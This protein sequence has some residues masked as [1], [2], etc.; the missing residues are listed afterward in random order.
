MTLLHPILAAVASRGRSWLVTGVLVGSI[1]VAGYSLGTRFA[2]GREPICGNVELAKIAVDDAATSSTAAVVSEDHGI[3]LVEG[4]FEVPLARVDEAKASAR[5][6]RIVPALAHGRPIGTKLYAIRSGSIAAAL[7]LRNGDTVT[8]VNQAPIAS[9]GN[10]QEIYAALQSD[11]EL[12][13]D[14]LRRGESIRLR[15]RVR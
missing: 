7:G 10:A 2:P 15:Y 14:V 8:H 9:P 5:M 6:F 1:G 4:V 3:R 12:V 13:L 11:R